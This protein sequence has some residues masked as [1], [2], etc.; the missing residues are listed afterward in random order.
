MYDDLLRTE[1]YQ[2]ARRV[3]RELQSQRAKERREGTT[4]ENIRKHPERLRI[5]YPEDLAIASVAANDDEQLSSAPVESTPI[6][7]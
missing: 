2:K 6:A 5:V 1:L 3:A 7:S 4:L